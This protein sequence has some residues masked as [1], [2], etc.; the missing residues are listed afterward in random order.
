MC[1]TSQACADCG[2]ELGMHELGREPVEQLGV[3]R[4]FALRSE[5]VEHL[6]QPG[7]E[8]LAPGAIDERARGQRIVAR[9]PASSPDR[10]ASRAR[11][12]C[13]ACRGS[14]ESPGSTIGAESSIQLPRGRMRVSRRLHRDR[15]SRHE[16]STRRAGRAAV[17]SRCTSRI[18]A[19]RPPDSTIPGSRAPRSV[20][21]VAILG[22]LAGALS[23]RRS[24]RPLAQ[25]LL[26]L[27]SRLRRRLPASPIGGHAKASA[28]KREPEASDDGAPQLRLV[29]QRDDQIV[30]SAVVCTGSANRNARNG[31][32]RLA[33]PDAPRGLRIAVDGGERRHAR[34]GDAGRRRRRCIVDGRHRERQRPGRLLGST[35]SASTSL[36]RNR[37]APRA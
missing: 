30:E 15:S 26:P 22:R 18:V 10:A 37:S 33:E 29:P 2:V 31:F 28:D 36:S 9:R 1:L 34:I 13:R 16:G 27:A 23:S 20:P 35:S 17:S 24:G 6:R 19:P 3:R 25:V 8:E 5:I 7:A 14:A 12:S 11:R 21:R 32:A 4:P